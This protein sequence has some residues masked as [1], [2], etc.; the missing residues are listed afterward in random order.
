MKRR[1]DV[2]D[3]PVVLF[4]FGKGGATNIKCAFQIN[5]YHRAEAVWRKLFR[6]AKKISRRSVDDD[7][8]F[9]KVFD[10]RR[11]S[12]L[13]LVW[14]AYVGGN[15]KCLASVLFDCGCRRFKVLELATDK[16]HG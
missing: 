6:S 12:F 14:I 8:D 13:Y 4:Q 7:V 11:Y 16:C 10:R 3:L 9:A 5:I 1:A 15:C 2:E